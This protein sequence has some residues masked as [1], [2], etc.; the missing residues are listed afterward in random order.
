MREDNFNGFRDDGGPD[1]A[2]IA[3][4]YFV[5]TSLG[6]GPFLS[7]KLL[8]AV[9][10]AEGRGDGKDVRAESLVFEDFFDPERSIRV[11]AA[12]MP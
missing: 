6:S 11:G 3:I 10:S 7:I 8:S 5:F 1:V 4:P 9:M 2:F 12:I